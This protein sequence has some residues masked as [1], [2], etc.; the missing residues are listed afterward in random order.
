MQLRTSTL[1]SLAFGALLIAAPGL[2]NAGDG[3]SYD[4]AFAAKGGNGKGNGG[5]N[6][7][8][9]GRGASSQSASKGGGKSPKSSSTTEDV[10][11]AS[12]DESNK[13]IKDPDHPSSLGRWNATKDFMHPS[14][15]A[16]IR[17]G[18]FNGTIGMLARFGLALNTLGGLQ[19]QAAA[20]A[21]ASE[22]LAAALQL[23]G[24]GMTTGTFDLTAALSEYS[25]AITKDP[26]ID[27]LIAASQSLPS[28][29]DLT[30]AAEE[31]TAAEAEMAEASNRSSWD[32]V[33]SVVIDRLGL[34]DVT[35]TDTT[36]PTAP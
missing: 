23:A 2:D 19:E 35:V 3:V 20:A 11:V 25:A 7:N 31:L 29:E 1:L 34:E 10:D 27:G 4:Q 24:Y 15:Q 26:T 32:E 12:L 18:N 17:N 9:A 22:D 21:Q 13:K 28:E 14:I 36:E 16:H 5:G 33:R 8:G 30:A 6:G